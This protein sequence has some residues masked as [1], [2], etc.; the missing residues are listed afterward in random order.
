MPF[1]LFSEECYTWEH[2]SDVHHFAGW[3]K[4]NRSPLQN[5]RRESEKTATCIEDDTVQL[6]G[7][8]LGSGPLLLELS[9]K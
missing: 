4:I 1:Q 7:D 6:G 3:H 9:M 8:H 2:R 5:G